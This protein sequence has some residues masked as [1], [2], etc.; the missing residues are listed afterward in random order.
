M[1]KAIQ[2]AKDEGL[3]FNTHEEEELFYSGY[4]DGWYDEKHYQVAIT[5]KELNK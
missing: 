5:E 3:D 1:K 4:E 2:A